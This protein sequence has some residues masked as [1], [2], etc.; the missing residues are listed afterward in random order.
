MTPPRTLL[1]SLALLGLTACQ[2]EAPAPA[3]PAPPPAPAPEEVAPAAPVEPVGTI[4]YGGQYYPAEWLLQG[5]PELWTGRGLEVEHTMFASAG[6][7]NEALIAGNIDVV[8]GADTRAVSMFNAIPDQALIIGVVHKGKKIFTMVGVDSPYQ[9][10]DD[11]KGKKVA[12]KF[13]TGAEGAMAKF[14]ARD[15]YE[16][17]EF[18]LINMG[19]AEMTPALEAGQI[20]A[21]T[22]WEPT[23]AIAEAK[24]V[25]RVLRS[26]EDISLVPSLIY[27][28]KAYAEAHPAELAAFLAAH[29]DKQ[30]MIEADPI[31]AAGLAAAAASAKG[32]EVP[33]AA[34]EK[35]YGRMSFEV[36]FDQAVI[37]TVESTAAFM[38]EKGKIEA[39]PTLAWDDSFL[40]TARALRGETAVPVPT[41]APTE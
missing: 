9:S 37:D 29:M 36:A 35:V 6:E 15:G 38:V 24:G 12:T 26:Y 18:E 3:E 25:G 23:P 11:L 10:W 22:A 19:L 41:E 4:R 7:A 2:G 17:T 39:A 40:E 14:W 27:T 31:G 8:C 33:A 16:R 13:G 34:F 5:K 21:F 1:C 20:D 32:V 28:T 30:D